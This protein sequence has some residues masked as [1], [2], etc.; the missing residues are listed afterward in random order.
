MSRS[1]S[2]VTSSAP[3]CGLKPSIR[4]SRFVVRDSSHTTGRLTRATTSRTGDTV[5]AM[6]S[7]R[8]SAMRLGTSSPSTSER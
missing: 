1:S 3:W 2:W 7:A 4:T 6:A 5:S 8:C